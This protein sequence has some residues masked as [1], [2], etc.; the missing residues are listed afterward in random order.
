MSSPM[1]SISLPV[2]GMSCASCVAHVR[3][4][5]NDLPGVSDLRDAHS[6]CD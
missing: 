3:R 4:A 5:L 2:Q 1:K 6:R